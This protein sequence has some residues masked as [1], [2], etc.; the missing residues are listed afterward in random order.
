MLVSQ[1]EWN[2]PDAHLCVPCVAAIQA[3]SNSIPDPDDEFELLDGE[4]EFTFTE[5]D[6]EDFIYEDM[7]SMKVPSCECG[8]AKIGSPWHSRWC[9]IFEETFK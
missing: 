5:I 3:M 1:A 2:N 4:D 8:A 9:P 7:P 6:G